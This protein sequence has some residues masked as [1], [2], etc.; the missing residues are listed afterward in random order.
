[1]VLSRRTVRRM[2]NIKEFCDFD[3]EKKTATV[4]LKFKSAEEII[5]GRLSTPESPVVKAEVP[6]MLE[7]YLEFVP[8]EFKVNFNIEIEDYMGY[9]SG[10]LEEAFN[11]TMEVRDYRAKSGYSS[12][13]SKMAVFVVV[14]LIM[15]LFV[16]F[17]SRYKWFAEAGLPFSATI[18]FVLELMFELY[19]E[20]G[21]THFVVSKIYDRFGD[22]DRFG[23][24]SIG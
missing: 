14:G 6:E 7:G 23:T 13:R 24:I 20:E 1:M 11:N 5:S 17:N 8:G 3:T 21:L 12:K 22:E 2:D 4:H 16:I 18:A 10:K 15:L 19:F 9:D